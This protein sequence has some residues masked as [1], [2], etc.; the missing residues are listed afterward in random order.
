M[1]LRLGMNLGTWDKLGSFYSGLEIFEL[2]V[3]LSSLNF[4]LKVESPN[5]VAAHN[6]Q[7]EP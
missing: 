3:E 4:S 5:T 2:P 7:F 6:S 1:E